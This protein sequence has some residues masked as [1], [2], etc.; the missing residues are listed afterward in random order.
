M[1]E[2]ESALFEFER[3]ERL[4][5]KIDNN[6]RSLHSVWGYWYCDVLLD[7]GQFETV[8]LRARQALEYA[9]QELSS[10]MG[11]LLDTAVAFLSLSR[12]RTIPA[13]T[14]G[15]GTTEAMLFVEQ[16]L[17]GINRVDHRWMLPQ[18]LLARAEIHLQGENLDSAH[19][20][21]DTTEGI[22][23]S[24]GLNL[25]SVDVLLLRAHIFL[26]E[27][28]PTGARDCLGR[29]AKS[30]AA[31]KYHRQD[32]PTRLL[33]AEACAAQ[34]E[35]GAA[36]SHRSEAR[37]TIRRQKCQRWSSFADRLGQI[38]NGGALGA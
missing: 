27:G 28:N 18:V 33:M 31:M 2:F 21:L 13:W 4:L 34:A 14:S 3:A 1:G 20:D 7:L 36:R 8:E 29:A 9:P 35:E 25:Y 19:Q 11:L 10:G 30:A 32:A 15:Y 17:D 12:C 6:T 5:V 37:A 24:G 16:S 22:V 26:R 23:E 38:V